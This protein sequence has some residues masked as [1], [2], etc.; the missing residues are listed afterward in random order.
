MGSEG[1]M[2]ALVYQKYLSLHLS[3]LAFENCSGIIANF[4]K[5]IAPSIWLK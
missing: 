4:I 3:S 1:F 5:Y 2:C